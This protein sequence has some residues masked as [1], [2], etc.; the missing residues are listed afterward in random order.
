MRMQDV[1]GVVTHYLEYILLFVFPEHEHCLITQHRLQEQ[2]ADYSS[3]QSPVL[4]YSSSSSAHRR[5]IFWR[6][7]MTCNDS[8]M[9]ASQR[10]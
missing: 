8:N 2:S 6:A 10:I 1:A 4:F 7:P 5:S 3:M 9:A